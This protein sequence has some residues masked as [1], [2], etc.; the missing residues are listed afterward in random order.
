MLPNEVVGKIFVE[1]IASILESKVEG[2]TMIY[3][4]INVAFKG[5]IASKQKQ[6]IQFATLFIS[7]NHP[8]SFQHVLFF[9]M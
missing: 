8:Q 6:E 2:R 1:K 3:D 5:T 9:I 4:M 7:L